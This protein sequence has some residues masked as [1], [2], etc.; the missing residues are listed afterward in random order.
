MPKQAPLW[1]KFYV[2]VLAAVLAVI[3]IGTIAMQWPARAAWAADSAATQ[4]QERSREPPPHRPSSNGMEACKADI[5]KFCG[6]ANLIQECLVAHWTKISSGCQ[7]EL[8]TPP[9]TDEDGGR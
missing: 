9:A 5:A 8:A 3:G 6:D 7:E 4:S 1:R 2:Q